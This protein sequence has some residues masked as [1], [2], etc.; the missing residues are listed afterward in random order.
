LEPS[1]P[2]SQEILSLQCLP[3]HHRPNSDGMII[4]CFSLSVNHFFAASAMKK[5]AGA[6]FFSFL[7]TSETI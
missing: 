5:T 1:R 2:F 6:V 3:F 7:L 4:S